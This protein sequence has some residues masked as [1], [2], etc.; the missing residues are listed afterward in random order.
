M[1]SKGSLDPRYRINIKKGMRAIIS[2]D[3]GADLRPCHVKE[4]LTGDPMH[5]SGIRVSCED[6]SMGRIKY[7]GTETAY[8]SPMELITDL[9]TR[10]R[11]LIVQELSRNDP[12]WWNTKIHPTIKD[13]VEGEKLK[14]KN[15]KQTLRIPEYKLIEEVYFSDLGLILLSRK[16]WQ[17]YFEIIFHDSEAL[18][19]KLSE[20]SHCR[21]IAAHSKDL[22]DH[23]TKKIQVYYDDIVPLLEEHTRSSVK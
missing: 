12:D 3:D 10:L 9:E 23:L 15:Y 1:S 2:I 4:I 5:E 8:M 19:V 14:G 20:L 21:N 6:G 22:T 7:I 11:S 13:R 16:N 17:R 18:R